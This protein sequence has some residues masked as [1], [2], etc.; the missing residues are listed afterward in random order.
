MNIYERTSRFFV[1]NPKKIFFLFVIIT[2][3]L[4]LSYLFIPYRGDASTSPK[5]PI[6][7]LD[8]QIS[9]EFS[10]E[11][12]FAL[13][14]LEGKNSDDILS[15][16]NLFKIY[17]AT[18]KLRAEDASKN[19]S[20]ET[21]IGSEHLY[22][23]IDS[24]TGIKVNGIFT[25]ADVVN[26]VLIINP[27]YNKTL[28]DASNNEVKKIISEVFKGD[29]FKDIKRNLSIHSNVEKR[30]INNQEID[31][32]TS[33]AMMIAVLGDNDSLGGGSQ[34]VAISGDKITLDKEKF[35]TNVMN[36]LKNELKDLNVWGI[37]IDVNLEGERQG[38]S[39]AV[40][41]TLTVIAAI[42]I[43]GF[44]LRSYWAVVLIGIGLSTLMIWLKGFSYLLGLKGG[45]VSD[46]IVPIAMVAFGVDFG[47]HAIRR[48]QEEKRANEKRANISYDKKFVIA[49]TGVGSALTLAFI[50]DAIAFL[51]NVTAA[52]E[53]IIHFGLAAGIATFA[54]YIVLGI[55]AP[56]LLS[57]IESIDN[58]NNKNKSIWIAQAIGSAALAGG[59]V[60]TFLVLSPIYGIIMI[61]A[62]IILCLFLPLYFA[63][64]AK[65]S[66][67]DSGLNRDNIFIK[68]EEKFS[69]LIVF[70]AKKPIYTVLFFSA[71]TIYTTFLAFK[72]ESSFEV[73]D[74]FK[75]ESD[76]VIGLD[77]LDYHLGDTIGELG[78]L[79]FEGD[80]SEPEAIDD[81]KSLLITLKSK[82]FLAHDKDGNLLIIEPN[83]ISLLEN[84]NSPA[85][86]KEENKKNL[87][88]LIDQGLKNDQD[89]TIFTPSRIKTTLI[90]SNNNYATVFRVGIPDSAS[91]DITTLARKELESELK[92]FQNK[93]YISEY[94]ITG[95]PFVRD[96][97]LSSSRNSLYRAIPIA[98]VASFLVLLI[99]FKSF[100]YAFV[101]IL[102][103]GLVVSWLYG[104]MYIGG[105]SLNLV[106]ATIGAISIGV[107]IDFS[108]HITQRFREEIRKNNTETALSKTL[109]GTGI[110]LLGSAIS[111]IAGFI[112]M[113]FA[114]MPMF[115]SFGKLTAIMIFLALISSVFV[116]PSLLVMVSKKNE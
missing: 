6:I 101:T 63:S 13:F 60:I 36:V 65:E 37:A 112:I 23:Y 14:I 106:T 25:I 96:V 103:I 89:E 80:L 38:L 26:N 87:D 40:Y 92:I 15:K 1:A 64:K 110:A 27:K 7:D 114:P 70:F 44:S 90:R 17:N 113:G 83:F 102:P 35:N 48:Y 41:I 68:I 97:E 33:P 52:T 95:S 29:E 85:N 53:S 32:W 99:A 71:I 43:V 9:N 105:Y 18:E 46:L 12:H 21:I 3:G 111:S 94:G 11:V 16:E 49:F 67:V 2:I 72:L 107:G 79:Y 47:V 10:D 74:F 84:I 75:P 93:S 20:P 58:K 5:D 42:A 28:K 78:E 115:A 39:S 57:K 24:D 4:T 81:M 88:K 50:S 98:A 73:S 69:A 19:L 108:I 77:K 59:S 56:F 30:M 86:N 45:L 109:N 116:L 76:F 55:Y 54:A 31:W 8:I 100:R 22:K 61:I 104:I 62:N 82:D 51:S 66:Q 91:Q 34:R